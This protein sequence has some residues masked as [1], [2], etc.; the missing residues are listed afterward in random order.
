MLIHYMCGYCHWLH[1]RF[2]VCRVHSLALVPLTYMYHSRYDPEFKGRKDLLPL[3]N[4]K[5]AQGNGTLS[6]CIFRHPIPSVP[7]QLANLR[8][9][10]LELRQVPELAQAQV[11]VLVLV[12]VLL[13]P[14]EL[15]PPR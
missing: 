15:Q 14:K 9:L 12:L 2:T 10:L 4:R 13:Q 1:V 8:L 11:Q 7:K 6:T 3:C 5:D